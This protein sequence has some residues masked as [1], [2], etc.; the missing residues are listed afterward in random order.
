MESLRKA[1][2]RVVFNHMVTPPERENSHMVF[3]GGDYGH[4][5][6]YEEI[7]CRDDKDLDFA[8]QLVKAPGAVLDLAGGAGRFS[9]RLLEHGR[10][11]ALV[12]KSVTMLEIARRR[13]KALDHELSHKFK[14]YPQDISH[15]QI[16]REFIAIFSINNGLEHLPDEHSILQALIRSANHLNPN[17]EM[18]VDVHYPVYWEQT[19]HWKANKWEYSQDFVLKDERYRVWGRTRGTENE[20]EVVWEHAITRN[21]FDYTFL[22]TRLLILPLQKWHKLFTT[23]GFKVT[24]I[25][26]SWDGKRMDPSLPKMIFQLKRI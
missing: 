3:H 4:G 22:K 8:V 9:L 26:G 20:N 18:Y 2:G 25:W 12:D 7:F 1:V 6:L 13:K 19:E 24:D 14:I 17:G 11:V 10:D 5:Y 15:M 23:A 21:L 16:G